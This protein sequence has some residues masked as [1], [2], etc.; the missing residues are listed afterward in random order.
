MTKYFQRLSKGICAACSAEAEHLVSVSWPLH[1]QD[2]S[3]FCKQLFS[4]DFP[5]KQ[6]ELNIGYLKLQKIFQYI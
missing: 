2:V 1:E 5:A 6:I 3:T 4:A